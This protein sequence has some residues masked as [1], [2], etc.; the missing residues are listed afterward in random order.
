[1]DYM[2][3]LVKENKIEM[4]LVRRVHAAGGLCVK[5]RA[6]GSRGF[7]DRVV[8]LPGSRVI[9]VECK[10][11]RGGRFAA[12][13]VQYAN[14]FKNLGLA[15]ALIRDREDIDALLTLP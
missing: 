10:R 7:F 2:M 4:E 5:V 9:F 11:P 14:E 15:V 3:R 6:I 8:A 12:H 13:Q 1:M